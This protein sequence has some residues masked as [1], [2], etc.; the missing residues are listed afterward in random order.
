LLLEEK[1]ALF[2]LNSPAI[3][4]FMLSHWLWDEYTF[5]LAEVIVAP[6]GIDTFV[7]RKPVKLEVVELPLPSQIVAPLVV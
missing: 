1:V 5:N 3:L 2:G 7:K 4:I 6:G